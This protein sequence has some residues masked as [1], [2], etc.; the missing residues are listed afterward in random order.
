MKSLRIIGRPLI[1]ASAMVPGP[2]YEPNNRREA[3]SEINKKLQRKQT[4]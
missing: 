3:R 1:K 4:L 2:A